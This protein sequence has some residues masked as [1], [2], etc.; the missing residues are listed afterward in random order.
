M[1]STPPAF[2]VRV[3]QALTKPELQEFILGDL[4]ERFFRDLEKKN[5]CLPNG[6]LPWAQLNF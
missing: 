1:R 3:F 5:R 6:I 2:F 4:E